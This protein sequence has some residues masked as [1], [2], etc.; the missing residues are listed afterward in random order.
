[1]YAKDYIQVVGFLSQ[2]NL[3]IFSGDEGGELDP[4][5]DDEQGNPL[6]GIAFTN[7]FA[8]SSA[9]FQSRFTAKQNNTAALTQVTEWIDFIG[10]GIFCLKFCHNDGPDP[11]A[12]CNHI[13]DEIGCTYNAVADYNNING[14]FV[15][16][17]SDD[18][19]P[20]GVFTTAP[21]Q[22]TTWVQPF[23]GNPQPPYTP[24]PISS[25]NCQTYQSTDLWPAEPTI[26]LV[27]SGS[28]ISAVPATGSSSVPAATSGASGSNG[29]SSKGSGP[30]ATGG[31][32]PSTGTTGNSTGNTGSG[33]LA[34]AAPFTILV[35]TIFGAF[36]TIAA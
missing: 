16:C 20:P 10:G 14:S 13:Y 32:S 35:A 27:T 8:D 1:L 7:G 12:L 11:A 17:D 24:N 26:R 29:A 18:M 31:T 30:A 9:S 36:F 19:T 23:T 33:A 28:V 34:L 5:G 4:H 21:G 3:N 25:S 15:V 2:Q 22:T 6:G